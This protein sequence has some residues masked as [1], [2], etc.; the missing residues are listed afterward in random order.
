MN[1][2]EK[3]N[4]MTEIAGDYAAGIILRPMLGNKAIPNRD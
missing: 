2:M 3:D 1:Q 4:S